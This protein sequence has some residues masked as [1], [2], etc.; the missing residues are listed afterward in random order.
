MTC[1]LTVDSASMDKRVTA[2]WR[3]PIE[4]AVNDV[5]VAALEEI[6]RSRSEP[7][8]RVERARKLLAYRESRTCSLRSP[9]TP[10]SN[11]KRSQLDCLYQKSSMILTAWFMPSLPQSPLNQ[12][13]TRTKFASR[14]R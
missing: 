6:S 2:G 7:A 14:P 11:R 3:R 8:I 4:L 13:K 12:R 1:R 10:A 9:Q 5:E